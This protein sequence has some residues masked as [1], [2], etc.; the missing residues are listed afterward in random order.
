MQSYFITG[1]DTGVGKTYW[2]AN[3]IRALRAQGIPALGLKPIA[4]GD[5]SDPISL[6]AANEG[7]LSLNQINPLFFSA[8]LAPFTISVLE[9]RPIDLT[10]LWESWDH[11]KNQFP[12]PFLVEGAGGWCVPITRNFWIRE[13]AQHFGFPVVVIS[14]AGLGTINHTLLTVQSIRD[15]GLAVA[16]I[17]LNQFHGG[18][19]LAAQTN[20]PI[21]EDL[22]GCPVHILEPDESPLSLP[23]WITLPG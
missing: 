14:R 23:A 21:L 12:G 20:G 7:T 18:D 1:T 10:R 22:S 11:L 13:L 8:P 3:C 9:E 6:A 17:V 15:T 5:R 2:T 4:C 19:E 16:G